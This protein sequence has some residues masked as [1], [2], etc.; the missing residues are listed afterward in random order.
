MYILFK[1][2]RKKK[3]KNKIWI[4]IIIILFLINIIIKK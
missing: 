4:Q 3:V 1:I 2:E